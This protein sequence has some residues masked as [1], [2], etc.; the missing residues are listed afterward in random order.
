MKAHRFSI[1]LRLACLGI[2]LISTPAL[3]QPYAGVGLGLAVQSVKCAAGSSCRDNDGGVKLLAGYQVDTAW[4]AELAYMRPLRYFTTSD[5]NGAQTWGGRYDVKVVGVSTGYSFATENGQKWQARLGLAQVR[6]SFAS[7]TAGVSN[8]S[9]NSVQPLIG[10]G[11]RKN[12]NS[13]LMV[14]LDVDVTR[15]KVL[16]SSDIFGLVSM[17][18]QQRF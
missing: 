5:S 18:L 6:A 7:T 13:D 2:L 16:N 8:A 3:A 14:R 4:S 17:S 10:F 12:L 1:P 11:T 9:A 15:S